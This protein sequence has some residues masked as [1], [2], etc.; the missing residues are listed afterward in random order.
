MVIGAQTSTNQPTG[1]VPEFAPK[2]DW[3]VDIVNQCRDA[4]VPYYIKPN[5][6]L[7]L[8][9]MDLPKSLPRER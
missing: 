9:G 6:G 3:I 8:P 2:F 7:E 4:G 5:A 1:Y